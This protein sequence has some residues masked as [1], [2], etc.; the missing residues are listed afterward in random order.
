MHTNAKSWLE[1]VI[2]HLGRRQGQARGAQVHAMNLSDWKGW[3]Q[4][5][6]LPRL[7]LRVG[8]GSK[9]ALLEV[10]AYLNPSEGK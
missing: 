8:S 4:D 6:P 3:S 2:E 10:S 7:H 9:G 1:P 5:A